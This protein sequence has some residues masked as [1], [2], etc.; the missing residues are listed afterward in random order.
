M[1][2]LA[3]FSK[4]LVLL[5]SGSMVMGFGS[6]CVPENFLVDK[7]GEIVNGFIIAGVNLALAATGLGIQ[8]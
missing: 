4:G 8:I 2:R 6:G 7:S 5:A 1:S 3:R